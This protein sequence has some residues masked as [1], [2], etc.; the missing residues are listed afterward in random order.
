[1]I[2]ILKIVMLATFF[3]VLFPSV[4]LA[5]SADNVSTFDS[6]NMPG[7]YEGTVIEGI[8]TD[9]GATYTFDDSFTVGFDGADA[10]SSYVLLMV[11]ADIDSD[12]NLIGASPYSIT[13][14]DILYVDQRLSDSNGTISFDVLPSR[15]ANS[16]LLLGGSFTSGTLESP[17]VLGTVN[18]AGVD[19]SG[20][21]GLQ[22]RLSGKLNGVTIS[23]IPVAGDSILADTD[24]SGNYLFSGVSHGDYRLKVEK[25]G[26]LSYEKLV[27]T[28]AN[29][30]ILDQI[31]L[32]GG[33]INSDGQVTSTDLS[34][35][36][37]LYLNTTTAVSDI[38]GDGQVTSTDLSILLANYLVS[39]TV[40]E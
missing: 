14:D 27:L 37:S 12:G 3:T 39:K 5:I 38:N 6:V 8:S 36:L 35:L 22:G 15:V 24:T 17:V 11:K 33:D 19:V 1:M 40:E 32:K 16:V 9:G 10:D 34:T 23:L 31:S 26:Y 21:V 29:D 25:S 13:A 18:V 4:A 2:K 7:I 30:L 28:I 20:A